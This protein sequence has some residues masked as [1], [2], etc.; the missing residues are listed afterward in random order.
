V[1]PASR[2][3]VVPADG[4]ETSSTVA[5]SAELLRD[6]ADGRKNPMERT[7]KGKSKSRATATWPSNSDAYCSP[8]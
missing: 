5:L 2:E 7:R 8:E 1:D 6:I 3:G 4:R